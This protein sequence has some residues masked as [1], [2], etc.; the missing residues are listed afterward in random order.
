[1]T[2]YIISIRKTILQSMWNF[3]G[4]PF[5]MA[6]FDQAWLPRFG[7]TTLEEERLNMV[8]PYLRG[9]LLDIG[10][11]PNT[12][13]RRY[14]HGVGVDIVAWGGG[15]MVVKDTACLPFADQTFETITFIACLNHI[16][17]RQAVLREARRLIK[18]D[19]QLI[20]TMINPILG[21]IGHAIWWYSEDK[22]R[23][24]MKEGE[25]GGLWTRDIVYLCANAG[26]QLHLHHRFVYWM[27]NL[28]LFKPG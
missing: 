7:W 23:G 16:P 28:Y 1:M 20:I 13:V 18:P 15:T 27:N 3:I 10:S 2:D 6:L 21:D 14:G 12:L 8:F 11:G 22:Q 9:R 17:N 26:F 24:G 5:R 19:G 4:I 25:V